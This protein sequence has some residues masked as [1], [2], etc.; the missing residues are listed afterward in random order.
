MTEHGPALLAAGLLA[1]AATARW[2]WARETAHRTTGEQPAVRTSDGVLL[3]VETDGPAD[4]SI[5]VVFA[6]GF[7]AQLREYEAQRAAL[8]GVARL[9]LFDQRGHGRSG[10]GGH[11]SA[12]IER[13][14]SDLGEVIDRFAVSGPVV[15]VAHSLGGM[16]LMA[17]AQQRAE[18]FGS[19]VVGVVLLSSSAGRLASSRLPPLLAHVLL[20][21][22][23]ARACLWVAWVVAPLVDR[24]APFETSAGR[25]WLRGRLFGRM[26]P[27]AELVSD[28]RDMW[29]HTSRSIGAAFYPTMLYHDGSAGLRA[30]GSVRSLVLAGTADAAIPV[31]HSERI[32]ATLGPTAQLVLVPGAGHM[33]N[34][35]HAAAVNAALVDLLDR[36]R[37][38]S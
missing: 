38:E 37:S 2:R 7:A 6:H 11:S 27:P 1:G 12:T 24:I 28:M 9:V 26:A 23:I 15:V 13:L 30:L 8:S 18:L 3:H 29:A 35:T 17:L 34:M 5:T 36:I 10:W 21:T 31:V 33:V 19:K 14:G 25:K 32:A 22:G 4:G 20:H 16:G